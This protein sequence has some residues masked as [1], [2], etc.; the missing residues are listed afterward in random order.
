[1][2]SINKSKKTWTEKGHKKGFDEGYKKGLQ[3]GI[4]DYKIT[5]TCSVCR[6]ELVMMPGAADHEAM[7]QLMREKGWA[8]GE[9]LKQT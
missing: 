6:G 4:T 2:S 5:Y 3:K 7:K 9:C 1:M 8:H